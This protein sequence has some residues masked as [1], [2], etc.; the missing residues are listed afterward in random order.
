MLFSETLRSLKPSAAGWKADIGEDWSQGR[1]TFGGLVAALGNEAM[2]Q[3]VAADRPLRGLNVTFAG[4]VIAGAV[5]IDAQ[6][7]RVGGAATI[8]HANLSS[9]NAIAATLTGVYGSARSTSITIAPAAAETACPVEDLPDSF[10]PAGGPSFLQHFRVRWAEGTRPYTSTPLRRSKAYIRHRDC[11]A[12]TE[13]HV[14]ALIDCI[15]SPVLQMMSKPAPASSMIWTLELLSHDYS[16]AVDEWWRID[17]EVSSSV[18]GYASQTSLISNP[19]GVA[20]AYS[21]QLVAVFG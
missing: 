9:A 6:V 11:G 7:L 8:A 1:A 18:D 13:S 10:L 12:L 21:R 3:Q 17:T 2:R 14:V 15:P 16:F 5:D 4:P 19:A 20:A